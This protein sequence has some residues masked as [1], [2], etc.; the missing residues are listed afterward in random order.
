MGFLGAAV[1]KTLGSIFVSS[2]PSRDEYVPFSIRHA[3][4]IH[5]NLLSAVADSTLSTSEIA[6]AVLAESETIHSGLLSLGWPNEIDHAFERLQTDGVSFRTYVEERAKATQQA[7]DLGV[8]YSLRSPDWRFALSDSFI[9][10]IERADKKLQGRVL[11]AITKIAQSPTTVVGDTVK[12]LTA[13]LKGLWRYRVGDYRLIYA[14]D[15]DEKHI[16]LL[17]F[18]ARGDVY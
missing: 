1:F 5:A 11:E 15:L 17:S 8:R 16:T 13:D 18:E 7:Y 14:A 3:N 12:P 2:K 4:A 6:A 9:K 10:S